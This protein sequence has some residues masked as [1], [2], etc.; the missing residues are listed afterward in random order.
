[1][2]API[3]TA[4]RPMPPTLVARE[5]PNIRE[6]FAVIHPNLAEATS[7][8]KQPVSMATRCLAARLKFGVSA[9]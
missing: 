6:K 8:A 4:H 2:K 1:M 5:P 7:I 9:G 3:T